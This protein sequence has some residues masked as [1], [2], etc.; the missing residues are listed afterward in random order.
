MVRARLGL[1][2]MAA[3]LAA[4]VVACDGT[5]APSRSSNW[6]KPGTITS[7]PSGG[8][9]ATGIVVRYPL[10]YP[11]SSLSGFPK[12]PAEW[13]LIANPGTIT[14]PPAVMASL[15]VSPSVST[16]SV[17]DAVMDEIRA[18]EGQLVTVEGTPGPRAFARSW[19]RLF[20]SR[21][22]TAPAD[23][24]LGLFPKQGLVQPGDWFAE[25]WWRRELAQVLGELADKGGTRYS[26]AR[27]AQKHV[28]RPLL[29]PPTSLAGTLAA[30]H[31]NARPNRRLR[32]VTL[33]F[34]GG[35]RIVEAGEDTRPAYRR[36]RLYRRDF[37][38]WWGGESTTTVKPPDYAFYAERLRDEAKSTPGA[39]TT[40][41][42]ARIRGRP[43]I[44]GPDYAQWWDGA[45]FITIR[46]GGPPAGAPTRED[47]LEIA[48]SM[49]PVD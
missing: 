36:Q 45:G 38:F 41:E 27:E 23:A 49:R 21:V 42:V 33:L 13:V 47:L 46:Y 37:Y 3:V 29:V 6:P 22:E 8:V 32:D 4:G 24:Q 16:S 25:A 2:V 28:D 9:R 7:T 12:V 30:V 48:R 39:A 10:F 20:V 15:E 40:I 19:K 1:V 35:L 44:W 18:A 17:M 31:V 5:T 11:T 26:D 14:T 43:G 34:E